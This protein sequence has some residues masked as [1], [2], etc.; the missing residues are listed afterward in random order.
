ML[1][2]QARTVSHVPG[3]RFPVVIDASDEQLQRQMAR[4]GSALRFGSPDFEWPAFDWQGLTSL[5]QPP[6]LADAEAISR[7]LRALAESLNK[8][9]TDEPSRSRTTDE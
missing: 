4:L 9:L 7:E 6:E 2:P 3:S 8:R 1:M 5:A